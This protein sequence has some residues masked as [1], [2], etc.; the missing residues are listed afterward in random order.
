MMEKLLCQ[1]AGFVEGTYNFRLENGMC[2]VNAGVG[3]DW[4]TIYLIET[5][6]KYRNRGE[7]QKLL[8]SLKLECDT[9]G[10]VLRLF[11]PMNPI[12]EHIC[13]KLNI[14]VIKDMAE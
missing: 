1:K 10:K 2:F 3:E 12:I 11:A 6:P 8:E 4:V 7:A 5:H 14:E 9:K 13:N